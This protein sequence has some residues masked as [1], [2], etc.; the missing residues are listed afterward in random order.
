[1]ML[2]NT[3]LLKARQE[4]SIIQ[5][6]LTSDSGLPCWVE[7][8]TCPLTHDLVWLVLSSQ[9]SQGSMI[10]A[11][12]TPVS[13]PQTS[14]PPAHSSTKVGYTCV[15][16]YTPLG[17]HPSPGHPS[18][19]HNSPPSPPFWCLGPISATVGVRWYM[20]PRPWVVVV[21]WQPVV[22]FPHTLL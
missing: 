20:C 3:W 13:A 16:H 14:G 4:N 19:P 18:S 17:S 10:L 8:L 5:S 7:E 9:S 22:W 2:K 21:A 12:A 11:Q 1:M 15:L 6:L